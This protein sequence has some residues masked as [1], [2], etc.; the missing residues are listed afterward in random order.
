MVYVNPL[1]SAG[2]IIL[3]IATL[4]SVRLIYGARRGLGC[5]KVA[6]A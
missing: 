6:I 4:W 3:G 2:F 5:T 1:N